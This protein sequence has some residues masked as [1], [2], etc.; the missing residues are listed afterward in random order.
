MFFVVPDPLLVE[1]LERVV[2]SDPLR[3]VLLV[4]EPVE[5][6]VR[7]VVPRV[8]ASVSLV[9]VRVVERVAPRA[10]GAAAS[11]DPVR[12]DERPMLRVRSLSCSVRVLPRPTA[13]VPPPADD[14]PEEAVERARLESAASSPPRPVVLPRGP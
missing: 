11:P 12:V 5:R 14:L 3:V 2:L 6:V 10:D 13:R 8:V 4:E 7:V 9:V 1:P